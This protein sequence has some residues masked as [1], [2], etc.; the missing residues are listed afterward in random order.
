[1]SFLLSFPSLFSLYL[2]FLSRLSLRLL[3]LCLNLFFLYFSVFP[4]FVSFLSFALP[5]QVNFSFSVFLSCL[6]PLR[7]LK[8]TPVKLL[9]SLSFFSIFL[10]FATSHQQARV[11]EGFRVG[12]NM[13]ETRRQAGRGVGGA[14]KVGQV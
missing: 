3:I 5:P 9:F 7:L 12:E 1:M 13:A 8:L 14:V 11:S 4:A 10:S 2:S 6:L